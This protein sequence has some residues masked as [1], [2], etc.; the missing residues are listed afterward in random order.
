M[1]SDA[2]V[3]VGQSDES[4]DGTSANKSTSASGSKNNV[5]TDSQQGLCF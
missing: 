5:C 2:I 3:H 1:F 4:S